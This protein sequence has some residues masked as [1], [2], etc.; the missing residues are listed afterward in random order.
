[1]ARSLSPRQPRHIGSDRIV[2][3]YWSSSD[4]RLRNKS[5]LSHKMAVSRL[6]LG[7]KRRKMA[8]G[9]LAGKMAGMMAGKMV[10]KMGM[11]GTVIV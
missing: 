3:C 6:A 1:M 7:R 8:A 9:S 11:R 5:L 2:G 10:G 4:G